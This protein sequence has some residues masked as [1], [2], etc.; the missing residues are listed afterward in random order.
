[1]KNCWTKIVRRLRLFKELR[2]PGQWWL[3]LRVFLF[4]AMVPLLF[5]LKLS[6]ANKWLRRCAAVNHPPGGSAAAGAQIIRCV[7]LATAIGKP[8]VQARC[9][10]RCATL[11]Y[12]LRRAGWDLTLCFGA[13]CVD[14]KLTEA[15]GHCWLVKDGKPFFGRERS[16][17]EFCPQSTP[18]PN[19]PKPQSRKNRRHDHARLFISW[20]EPINFGRA[21][22]GPG[23][24]LWRP[25]W[26]AF[27]HG[28]PTAGPARVPF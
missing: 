17:P 22:G 20:R 13:A 25:G 21:P 9:L 3:F 23:R 8:L 27:S 28:Q 7:E 14:G 5:S 11:F 24:C 18:Y 4:A 1:M 16:Q 2:T 10:T 6:V 15:A 19:L 12:F 26:D